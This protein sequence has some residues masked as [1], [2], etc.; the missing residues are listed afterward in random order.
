MKLSPNWKKLYLY[1]SNWAHAAQVA[2]IAAWNYLPHDLRQNIPT[3][4]MVG[5]SG[6]IFVFGLGG[7]AVKQNLQKGDD[8]G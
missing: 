4:Y 2:L 6:L 5:L 7:T 3:K 1:Y 8:N